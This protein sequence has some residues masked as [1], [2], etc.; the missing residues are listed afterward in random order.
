MASIFIGCGDTVNHQNCLIY[1]DRREIV[2]TVY[3]NDNGMHVDIVLPT[4]YNENEGY[5]SF[6]W[7]AEQFFI[8]VPTWSEAKYVDFLHV[9]TNGHEVVIRETKFNRKRNSWTP[10]PVSQE[11]LDL[12]RENIH[13]SYKYDDKGHRIKVNDPKN[14]GTYYKATGEYTFYNTCNT[15]TN[16]MLK[17]SNLYA[18]KRAYFSEEIINLYK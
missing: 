11:Q 4:G 14:N 9:I 12:L 3:L 5:T 7:G 18:R 10:V 8:Y 16:K 13:Y 15:W 1:G 6:G 2:D 17:N